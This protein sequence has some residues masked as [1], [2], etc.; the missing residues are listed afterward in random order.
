MSMPRLDSRSPPATGLPSASGTVMRGAFA[1]RASA[2]DRA[3][4]SVISLT[5]RLKRKPPARRPKSRRRG[6]DADA[7]S[8]FQGRGRPPGRRAFDRRADVAYTTKPVEAPAV[9]LVHEQ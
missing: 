4:V 5:A 7:R 3:S 1:T 9:L 6:I 8:P 2:A